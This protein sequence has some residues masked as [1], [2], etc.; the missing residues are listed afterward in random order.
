M[1]LELKLKKRDESPKQVIER[2]EFVEVVEGAT[3]MELLLNPIVG[4]G[5]N[6]TMKVCGMLGET[7]MVI[8][9][10]SGATHNFTAEGLISKAKILIEEI[11]EYSIT[12]GDNFSMKGKQHCKDLELKVQDLDITQTFYPFLLSVM[13]VVLRVE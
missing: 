7:E 13:D 5:G 6:H 4:F 2:N 3:K 8:M 1:I 10:D 9:I 12:I 11:V